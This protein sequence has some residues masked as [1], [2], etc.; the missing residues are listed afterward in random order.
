MERT[1]SSGHPTFVVLDGLRGVA[2]LVVAF[3][4]NKNVCRGIWPNS[5][6]LA[7]DFFFLL[8]GFVVALSFEPRLREGMSFSAFVKARM[9]RLYP[10]YIL[11][12]AGFGL[13]VVLDFNFTPMSW[14][15][16][17]STSLPTLLMLPVRADNLWPFLFPYNPVAWSLFC[18]IVANVLFAACLSRL[19]DRILALVCA[20]GA[21]GVAV[22]THA[23]GYFQAG[24]FWG[25]AWGGLARVA[26]SF[27]GGVLLFRMHDLRVLAL[28]PV[29]WLLPTALLCFGLWVRIP[30][31]W[32]ML[33]FLTLVLLFPAVLVLAVNSRPGPRASRWMAV[34]GV[35]SYPLYTLQAAVGTAVNKSFEVALPHPER[36]APYSGLFLV[37][38][39]AL[40]AYLAAVQIDIPVRR[41]L[42]RLSLSVRPRSAASRPEPSGFGQAHLHV[43][44]TILKT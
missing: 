19:T 8:S 24:P 44:S 20:A 25:D 5:Y 35:V 42:G 33:S 28:Q 2:A 23:N 38:V 9:I 21:L 18:E 1:K 10:M 14:P 43:P 22:S 36:Y 13:Y 17:L 15:D 27:F 30:P 4:H 29:H 37:A 39:C 26:L 12:T 32:P 16:L 41:S 11:G 3:G 31:R 6:N 40:V 7:V 34:L